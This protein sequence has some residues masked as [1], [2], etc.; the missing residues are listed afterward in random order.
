MSGILRVSKLSRQC[1]YCGAVKS[2]L[3]AVLLIRLENGALVMA[4]FY[5]LQQ[6][7]AVESGEQKGLRYRV[8]QHVLHIP[9]QAIPK[10]R[11]DFPLVGKRHLQTRIISFRNR[12]QKLLARIG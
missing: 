3:H 6:V 5:R 9:V 10:R 11:R 1:G 4:C 8:A 7:S 2:L 12:I